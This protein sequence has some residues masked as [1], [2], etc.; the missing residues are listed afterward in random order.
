MS[1][2]LLLTSL[3]GP[4]R[5]SEEMGDVWRSWAQV[6]SLQAQADLSFRSLFWKHDLSLVC[7]ALLSNY[8]LLFLRIVV[9]TGSQA[10]R[11]QP[12]AGVL[13]GLD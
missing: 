12:S 3:Y 4:L 9:D 6:L 5:G 11:C 7:G 10:S 1:M 8:S 13:K 2:V